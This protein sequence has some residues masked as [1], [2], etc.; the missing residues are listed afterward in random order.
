MSPGPVSVLSTV[1]PAALRPLL[2]D[3]T[4][5]VMDHRPHDRK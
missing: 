4:S 2:I 5:S 1:R 3:M